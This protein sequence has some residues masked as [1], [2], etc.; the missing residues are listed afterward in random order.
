[1]SLLKDYF[2]QTKK[3]E[4]F[5]GKMMI[6]GMNAGHG[7]MAAW[8]LSN[9]PAMNPVSITDL[10]CGGGKNAEELLKR[11]ENSKVTAIDYSPLSVEQT[12]KLNQQEIQNGRCKAI[13]GNVSSLPLEDEAFD[14]ATAF[15]TIY[16]WP[17][18]LES[19]K[20]VY[21]IL[22]SG[23]KFLIV[24]ECDGTN[25]KDDKW[26]NMI[27]GMTIYSKETLKSYLL[28]A[29]FKDVTIFH[30]EKK[31]WIAFLSEKA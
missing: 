12:M 30:D 26:V 20:E 14:F 11:Y 4:G 6:K 2:S 23:G 21:R 1:M 9:L 8:G 17:G 27:D 28:E 10:G 24:N 7:R 13:Q 22:E 15:E 18:P 5:M 19:F 29:G 25:K 16:F 3:P 31:H